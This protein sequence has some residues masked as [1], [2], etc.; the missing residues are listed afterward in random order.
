MKLLLN[1]TNHIDAELIR[2]AARGDASFQEILY[3]QFSKAM[4]NI[5]VRMMGNRQEAEDILQESFIIAFGN[6]KNIKDEL[7]F[8]GWL[9]R[10]VIRQCLSGSR[11]QKTLLYATDVLEIADVP[12]ENWMGQISFEKIH[13]AIRELPE[14]CR[15][16]FNLYAVED[17]PHK[18]IA[19]ELGI[20]E[21]TSK[22]QYQRARKLLRDKLNK[23]IENG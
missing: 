12:D 1:Y 18:E 10:I 7:S 6:L 22:S 3:Q 14:G 8:A 20:S 17:W 21:S 16:V 9:K 19:K 5:C 4:Y 23:T 11:K 2:A 13:D 15:Q